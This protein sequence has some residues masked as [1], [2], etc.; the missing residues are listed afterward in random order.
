MI[1]Q[2]RDIEVASEG[3]DIT[4]SATSKGGEQLCSCCIVIWCYICVFGGDGQSSSMIYNIRT[5]CTFVLQ[6][7]HRA[8]ETCWTHGVKR[9]LFWWHPLLTFVDLLQ[10]LTEML[11]DGDMP[12][13]FNGFS[14]M[15]KTPFELL[16][17]LD[18]WRNPATKS[19]ERTAMKRSH[20]SSRR[21]LTR[22]DL[23]V[24]GWK[25]MLAIHKVSV[26]YGR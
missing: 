23:S 20:R 4:S 16:N 8:V 11:N 5:K 25:G 17:Q 24:R 1:L 14:I 13:V 21:F 6:I 3:M 12:M 2:V 19:L 18:P 22:L 15:L 26:Y 10:I 9:C 7:K